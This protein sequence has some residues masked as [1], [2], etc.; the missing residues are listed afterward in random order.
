[1]LYL[2]TIG[3]EDCSVFIPALAK[4]KIWCHSLASRSSAGTSYL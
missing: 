2:T 4:R 1:M 3:N